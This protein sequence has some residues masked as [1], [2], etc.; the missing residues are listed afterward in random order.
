MAE[1]DDSTFEYEVRKPQPGL[2]RANLLFAREIAYPDLRPAQF[3]FTLDDWANQIQERC[4]FTDTVLT[5]IGHMEDYL[6]GELGLH[7]N[8]EQ[9]DD[10]RNSYLNQV[11]ARRLGLPI[12]L[13]AIFIEIG[14]RLG[15]QVEGVG[16][17]GHFIVGVQAEAG[18]YY[19]D[20]FNGGVEV[21]ED[22][23]ARLVLDSTGRSGRFDPTWLMP[24]SNRDIIARMLTN[25]RNVYVRDNS[26]PEA[27]ATVERLRMVQPDVTT[28]LRDLGL[29][30]FRNNSPR[31][32]ATHLEAYLQRDPSAPDARDMQRR[33]NSVLDDYARLN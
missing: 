15:L 24:T 1:F 28:H 13:S 2:A 23:A 11:M 3:L 16:M 25:L 14:S 6:F 4:R 33:L 30:H 27:V 20:P 22:D 7:G 32:A 19:F 29:L 21:T 31:L 26:W 8:H 5:R 12:A 9:Y 10:P 17:P 18:R